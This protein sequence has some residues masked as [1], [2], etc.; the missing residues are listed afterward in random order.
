[1]EPTQ[2]PC[3]VYSCEKSARSAGMCSAHYERKRRGKPIDGPVTRWRPQEIRDEEKAKKQGMCRAFG[4]RADAVS[5]R[6]CAEHLDLEV[7]KLIE[8][9]F[10][11][12][13]EVA[14]DNDCWVWRGSLTWKGYG[15]L[16]LGRSGPRVVAHRYALARATGPIPD[17]QVV[18]HL[19]HNKACCNPAHLRAVTPS[20]NSLNMRGVPTDNTSGYRGL[21]VDKCGNTRYRVRLT[22]RGQRHYLGSYATAEEAHAAVMEFHERHGVIWDSVRQ[23]LAG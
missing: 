15:R 11:R 19:C 3:S 13:V 16:R 2:K 8:E 21:E 6:L 7:P 9:K 22:V 10:L 23:G 5:L 18:D 12:F 20:E 1:M 17:D 14:G 4:C